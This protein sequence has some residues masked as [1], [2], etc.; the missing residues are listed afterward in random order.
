MVPSDVDG[1]R[2]AISR[3]TRPDSGLYEDYFHLEASV[4]RLSTDR[5][6]ILST[7]DCR[8]S[9]RRRSRDHHPPA[10]DRFVLR[11]RRPRMTSG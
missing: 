8:S 5:S 7:D 9:S 10:D 3:G 2:S 11:T 4:W 6:F 1:E